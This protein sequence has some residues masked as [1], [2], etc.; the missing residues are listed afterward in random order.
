MPNPEENRKPNA[1]IPKHMVVR[2][3]LLAAITEGSMTAGTR[4]PTEHELAARF[5]FSRQTIRQAIG[6]LE[7]EGWLERRQGIGTFISGKRP[8]T[9]RPNRTV[10]VLTTYLDDYIFPDIIR[11]IERVLAPAGCTLSLHITRNGTEREAECLRAIL[12]R[13]VDALIA[14]GTKSAFPSPNLELY[15][16]LAERGI[17]VL[18][19]NGGYAG[20]SFPSVLF[21]D[22]EAGR[23][24]TSWLLGLGHRELGGLFKVDDIQG[25]RRYAGFVRAHHDFGLHVR[26]DRIVWFTTEDQP[27]LSDPCNDGLFLRRFSGVTGICCY[28]DQAAVGAMDT[29]R[30]LGLTVPAD[31]SVV[32]IDDSSLASLSVPKLTTV[33][34]PRSILG[35]QA[36]ERI[37]RMMDGEAAPDTEPLPPRLVVRDSADLPAESSRWPSP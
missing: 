18:F 11:G 3:W 33:A 29:L 23:V 12:D 8:A 16:R 17:P 5:G 10:A 4:M 25:H 27:Q 22:E 24:A 32:G 20:L 14:E 15:R 19:I 9:S 26:E 31:V 36:A 1:P 2:E 37:L 28:N 7:T 34:H 6:F 30:R 21:D 35:T 13:P